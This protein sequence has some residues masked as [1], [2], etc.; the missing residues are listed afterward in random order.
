MKR[1]TY[2]PTTQHLT[3]VFLDGRRKGEI[4]FDPIAQSYQYF[5]KSSAGNVHKGEKFPTLTEVK[6]SLED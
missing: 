2:T 5:T 4:R 3:L 1:I 6:A